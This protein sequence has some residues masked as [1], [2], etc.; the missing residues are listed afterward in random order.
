MSGKVGKK[1]QRKG[2]FG[3]FIAK[4]FIISV[5]VCS[6]DTVHNDCFVD[7]PRVVGTFQ[8]KGVIN[9]AFPSEGLIHLVCII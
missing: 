5:F 8:L 4:I 3:R 2:G 6:T 1:E 9:K 7:D